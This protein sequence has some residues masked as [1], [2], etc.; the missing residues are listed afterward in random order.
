MAKEAKRM[1][2]EV[3][4]LYAESKARTPNA[5]ESD[6]IFGMAF[7]PENFKMIPESSQKRIKIC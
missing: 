6:I 5:P 3:T 7:D 2:R 1:A 4:K